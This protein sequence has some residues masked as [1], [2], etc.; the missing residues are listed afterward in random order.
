MYI[1]SHL[2]PF[3]FRWTFKLL[4]YLAYCKQ[5][6]VISIG[7]YVSFQTIL[8]SRYMPRSGFAGS[9]DSSGEKARAPHSSTVAWQIPWTEEPDGLK[10]MGSLRVGHDWA[11]S[12]SLSTFMHWRRKWLPTPEFFPGESHGR[13]SLVGCSPWGRT[14]SD[15]TEVT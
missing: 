3:L 9:Y 5:C 15:T 8:F 11:T 6:A 10:S 4:P 12:L 13:S 1:Y 2:Y 7:V 14:E